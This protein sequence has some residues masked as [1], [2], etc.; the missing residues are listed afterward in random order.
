MTT[1]SINKTNNIFKIKTGVID[2]IKMDFNVDKRDR[3]V[4][5][6]RIGVNGIEDPNCWNS[7]L[8]KLKDA[9]VTGF[10]V[11]IESRIAD[12]ERSEGQRNLPGWNF[13]TFFILKV[14]D[15]IG[16]G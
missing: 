3:C 10:N 14:G 5:I 16:D 11:N 4:Q 7:L 6:S 9:I 15:A 1:S 2:K 12:V 13:C 8:D